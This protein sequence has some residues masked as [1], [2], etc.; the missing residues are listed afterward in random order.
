METVDGSKACQVTGGYGCGQVT[1]VTAGDS[2]G[3]QL[4][5]V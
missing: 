2:A 3:I 1:V 5:L 4:Q